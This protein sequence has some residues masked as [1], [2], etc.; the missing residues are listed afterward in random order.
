MLVETEE[1]RDVL[2]SILCNK[3]IPFKCEF[4][5]L[6]ESGV[7]NY[8]FHKKLFA[9]FD[10]AYE[11]WEPGELQDL[12]FAGQK[13]QKNFDRFRKDLT[14]LAG[15]FE[16]LPRLNG[17]PRVEAKSLKFDL[18]D[19]GEKERLYSNVIN[20]VLQRILVNYDRPGLEEVL[21]RYENQLLEFD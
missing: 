17:E 8:K 21:R 10:F 6:N 9:L 18:M 14:I 7:N 5:R 19:D 15:Y 1:R 3:K 4:K 13:P 16:Y 12:R 2:I 20:V 11:A